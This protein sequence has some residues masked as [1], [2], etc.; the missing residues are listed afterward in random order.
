M[1]AGSGLWAA[2]RDWPV[3]HG[4]AEGT[5]YSS[6]RQ[7]DRR[8]VHQLQPAWVY[9]C[10]DARANTGSTIECNPL[11][12][13]GRMYLTTPGLR[14]VAVDAATGTERWVFDPWDG[15]GGGGV[16]R[17]L[18]TWAGRRI[19]SSRGEVDE[20]RRLF[21]AAGWKLYALDAETGRPI[22]GFGAG[23]FI[24]LREGL[25]QDAFYLSVGAPTPGVVYGDLL[26]M[27]SSVPDA[28]PPTAPGHVRAYDVRTG[29]RR[30]I[31]HTLP[32][33][34]EPGYETWG[35]DNWQHNGGANAWGGVTLDARA[36]VVY[37]GTG[38]ANYDHYGGDR[39][40][41]N[42]YANCILALDAATGALRWHFQAVHHDVWDYDLPCAPV[43]V[44]LR[45]G[46]RRVP[47]LVQSTKMGH[48]FV[49]DRRTGRPLFPVEER[50]VPSSDVPGEQVWPTQP[51][52]VK[53]PPFARQ[54]FRPDEV[55]HL[56]ARGS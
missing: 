44:D 37:C 43:L 34:G 20:A 30:W 5:H 33:P 31:F 2:D 10:G 15:K 42:L 48:L 39:P 23:G 27:G 4:D 47:A 24:D 25:D 16:N 41:A 18:A 51:F 53:P 52:P 12:L 29:Q 50:R 7:I 8:N 22:P 54:G 1:G 26:I 21:F 49:L 55:T 36:G 19:R 35:P 56:S 6:L 14:V 11:I 13:D 9:R 40:G 32:H 17:G 45:R 38:S 3:Y 28:L 46:W